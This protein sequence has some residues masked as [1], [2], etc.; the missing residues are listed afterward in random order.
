MNQRELAQLKRRLNPDKRNP[1]VL[2]GCYVD[3]SGQRI[4]SFAQPVAHLP[5]EENE[6]YMALFKRVLSGTAG[7]NLQD[8]DFTAAQVMESEEHRVLCALRESGLTDEE[9]VD[10]FCDRVIA[11]LRAVSPDGAQSVTEQQNAYNHLILLLYDGFDV[12]FRDANGEADL[13]RSTNVFSYFLCC[14]CPVKQTKPELSYFADERQF[15]NR[16]ADWTV[17]S[18]EL[19]FLFPTYEEGGANLYRALFY[20]RD[21]ADGHD[22]FIQSVFGTELPMPAARQQESFQTVLQDAL[23]DE[24]S[25]DV[26]QAVH[27]TVRTRLEEQ[28][29]D[30]N[31]EPLCLTKEDVKEVLTGCGVSEARAEAFENQYADAF[32]AYTEI[33]AVNVIAPKQFTVNTPSVSIRVDPQRSDLIE[34]RM[35]DGRCYILVLADGDVEVNGVNVKFKPE[36]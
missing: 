8:I 6:K 21:S 19:G 28:K 33:P 27:E 23:A 25:M 7:Q 22:A 24:C 10:A 16:L 35:I 12:D 9:A 17:A 14:V 31:A 26:I 18:P 3:A 4:S 36:A 30:K 2:R 15:H 1:T 5:A 34:T 20:T 32:G 11:A 13:E 29:A